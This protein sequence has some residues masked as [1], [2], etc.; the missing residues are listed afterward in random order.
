MLPTLSFRNSLPLFR[1]VFFLQ[2]MAEQQAIG[3][4]LA[5]DGVFSGGGETEAAELEAELEALLQTTEDKENSTTAASSPA[6]PATA[7]APPTPAASAVGG[8]SSAG[9][10]GRP[11]APAKP[12]CSTPSASES[13]VAPDKR[14]VSAPG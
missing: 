7:A 8:A 13:G 11:A 12:A 4:A 14:A 2:E 9:V 6:V 1:R 5:Q 10:T 3:A